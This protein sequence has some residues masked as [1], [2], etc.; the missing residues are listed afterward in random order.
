MTQQRIP[1][2]AAAGPCLD[3][4]PSAD[5]RAILSCLLRPLRLLCLLQWGIARFKLLE[6]AMAAMAALKKRVLPGIST[7]PMKARQQPG[8]PGGQAGRWARQPAQA[9]S[10]TAHDNT[11][12]PHPHPHPPTHPPHTH[13]TVVMVPGGW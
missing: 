3:A 5:P 6:D 9:A 7:I 12:P 8:Q 4:R 13:K 11:P 10:Y 2:S 1:Y